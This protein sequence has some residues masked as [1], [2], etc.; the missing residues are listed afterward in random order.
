M[1]SFFQSI[2]MRIVLLMIIIALVPLLIIAYSLSYQQKEE[3]EA[4]H[5]SHLKVVFK[6]TVNTIDTNIKYQKK[7]LMTVAAMPDFA[8][9]LARSKPDDTLRLDPMT[10]AYVTDLVNRYGFYDFFIISSTGKI[11]YTVKKEGDYGRNVNSPLLKNTGLAKAYVQTTSMLDTVIS[12]LEHYPP[13]GRK[14]SFIATPV[15]AGEKLV[16]AIAVQLNEN[17]IF[18][19]VKNYN[20]LG[21]T[22]EVV[23]G[24]LRKDGSIVAAIPLKYDPE[25]FA[26]GRILNRGSDATGMVQAVNGRS[27]AGEVRD[28]R[29]VV[30]LAVWGYEPTLEWGIVVKTDRDEVFADIYDDQKKLLYILI[31]AGAGIAALIVLSVRSITYPIYELINAVHTF[32]REGKYAFSK[33]GCRGEIC[34]LSE[35]FGTMAEEIQSYQKDLEAKIE[36]RTQELRLAKERIEEISVTDQLTGLYNRRHL[37]VVLEHNRQLY[38]RYHTPFCI[39]IFDIDYFKSVNDTYGHQI[40]DCV[41]K[42]V[43]DMLKSHCRSIDIVARWG[44]EEFLII[45]PNLEE[46]EAYRAA[47]KLRQA[48]QFNRFGDAG[49]ITISGGVSRYDGTIHDTLKRADDA[50]YLAKKEGRN[51]VCVVKE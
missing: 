6:E 32:R 38:E 27:G 48:I 43:A 30:S 7:L 37:D 14:A 44:G 10:E 29:G 16:G 34:Y 24:M 49:A 20:G 5:L 13:S 17:A 22:G 11:L 42:S 36:E 21:H 39:A 41:L 26:K 15:I 8:E 4:L 19:L 3:A 45:Y 51:R 46:P 40:G 1:R 31:M 2:T 33:I 12:P 47:E 28:Y 35:E 9:T 25:A 50:L 18:D 23:A